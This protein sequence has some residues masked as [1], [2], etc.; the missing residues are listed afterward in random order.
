[1]AKMQ[2]DNIVKWAAIGLLLV[3]IISPIDFLPLIEL[4]DGLAGIAAGY[5]FTK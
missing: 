3:Y 4:D 1:M 2:K 5:L